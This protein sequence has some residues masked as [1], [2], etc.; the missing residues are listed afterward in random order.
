MNKKITNILWALLPCAAVFA[1][2]LAGGVKN[3]PFPDTVE[4]LELGNSLTTDFTFDSPNI[5]I[6]QR[7]P[8]YPFCLMFFT[9]MGDYAFLAVNL[10]FLFG[11]TWFGMRLIEKW[12]IKYSYVLPILIFLSPGLI[13][14]ASVPLSE[15]AFIFFLTMSRYYFISDKFFVSSLALSAA[16]FCRPISIL[17]FL[18]F[19]IWMLWKKKKIILVLLFIVGA[20]LMPAFWMTRNYTS[21]MFLLQK[22]LDFQEEEK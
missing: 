18:L 4:Y 15:I 21:N 19:A 22:H 8:G 13:T 7:V 6:G 10:L 14:L 17:L 20:N 12:E 1:L 11:A 5:A 2:T 16:T 3:F 9:W